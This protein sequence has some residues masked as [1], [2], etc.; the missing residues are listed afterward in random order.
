MGPALQIQNPWS[1]EL[2]SLTR[3]DFANLRSRKRQVLSVQQSCWDAGRPM[4]PEDL[5]ELWP[6]DAK[7][8]PDAAGVLLED[9]LRRR[10]RGDDASLEEYAQRF[11]DQQPSL[12]K[13]HARE[14]AL[15]SRGGESD[16][17]PFSLR[18]PDVGDRIFGFRLSGRLGE[19]A[20]ARVFLAEQ[21]DLAGRPVVLKISNV[22]GDEPQTLA[23][24]LHT[25]IVPI[26]SLHDDVKAGLR[27]VCMPFLGGAS[28][29]QV[30]ERLWSESPRP[31]SGA[32]LVRA[33]E[34]VGESRTPASPQTMERPVATAETG[35]AIF[36]ALHYEH[37]AAWIVA[38]LAD[39]LE[40][41]HQRGIVHRDIKPSN[42]LV[43]DDG[44]PLLLDF[45]LALV[46]RADLASAKI[47]GTIAYMA[48]EHLHAL[49]GRTPELIGQ[50][51]RRSDIYSL[52]MVLA[53]MLLG[54]RPFEQ[55]GSYSVLPVQIKAIALERSKQAP[56]I[57]RECPD[58][59]WGMESIIRKCLAP[60]PQARYQRAEQ[61]AQDLR[62]L[63]EYRPLAYAPELSRLDQVRKFIRRHPRLTSSSS[64]AALAFLV[65]LAVGAVLVGVRNQLSEA[66]L[67]ERIRLHDAGVQQALCLINTR[68]QLVDHLR[69]GIAACERTLALFGADGSRPWTE[70]S[71]WL[72]MEP[73]LRQRLA[74]D[75]RELL[76]L[77]AGARMRLAGESTVA[78]R[79]ALGL[80]AQAEAIPGLPPSR[81]LL[82]D[83]A[84]YLKLCGQKESARLA[85]RQA[86]ETPAASARDHYLLAT[87]LVRQ[88]GERASQAAIREL[89]LALQLN[90]R[91]YWSL[92]E[93]GICR[94][95][96]AELVDAAADFGECIGI[97][98]DFAWGYF[99]RG[100][101]FERAGQVGAA[102]VDFTS[103]LDRD[104]GLVPAFINRG[105]ARLALK[106]YDG[107][108]AD[109][110]R[111]LT[112][113]AKN[114]SVTAGRGIALEG[115]GR[116]GE[117]DRAFAECSA[118][119]GD[120]PASA[121]S[122]LAWSMG[123]ALAA[124]DPARARAAF[125][126]ALRLDSKCAAALYGRAM[127]AMKDGENAEAIGHFE[128]A[129]E[130]EPGHIEARRYLA[131]ALARAGAW[132]RATGEI[133]RCLEREPRS[134]ASLYAAACVLAR[135]FEKRGS[136]PIS[137]QALDVLTRAF[138]LGADPAR[139]V[140]DPDLASI[141]HLPRFK[142]AV[143]GAL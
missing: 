109:F 75:R 46:Q 84:R 48:P 98:P 88:G 73:E 40:H 44:E 120:V 45:N 15:F 94:L 1:A 85:A 100:C 132:E 91:H 110:D 129:L 80:L 22:E 30:L 114:M 107:A 95:E 27:A 42:I 23:L 36:G 124:R 136:A 57:K 127:L 63:I 71:D 112:L 8:D 61:L 2:E 81:A 82:L 131:V 74:E 39:G 87:A 28:L 92:F 55:S 101:V 77:L 50:V 7:S 108:L 93:R 21:A 86:A 133:N 135:V 138:D 113:G 90:P 142:Q 119:L 33:L 9:Y 117:A 52:G 14:T 106:Q 16:R 17:P 65:F 68:L 53:E 67:R 118:N 103:A 89:E 41:A 10:G 78:A 130:A 123:F 43:S 4:R 13:A 105:L 49:L 121:R 37:A 54:H 139:A 12:V 66:R 25:N 64:V 62:R 6:I 47:G 18:L 70:S 60:D 11:P 26:Y 59:S 141:R 140:V 31:T 97:W 3:D 143:N 137:D 102:I 51:D 19:G 125:D 5:L 115:L 58:L 83:R 35:V 126:D 38:R 24:L 72:R 32:Q 111:A 128:R 79:D 99:N 76:M 69:E 122:R 34:A 116:H 56:S 29:S 96:R 20:F 134:P 104:S